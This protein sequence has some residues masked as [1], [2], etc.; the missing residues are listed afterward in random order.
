MACSSKLY[1]F[2][3]GLSL[4]TCGM[5]GTFGMMARDEFGN[6]LASFSPTVWANMVPLPDAA[7]GPGGFENRTQAIH[8]RL[9]EVQGVGSQRRSNR[10][11]A[12]VYSAGWYLLN[13]ATLVKGGLAATYYY[14][15]PR[16]FSSLS[17][18]DAGAE[19]RGAVDT[20]LGTPFEIRQDSTVDFSANAS[21]GWGQAQGLGMHV[22]GGFNVRWGGVMVSTP[23]RLWGTAAYNF[24]VRLTQSEQRVRLWA[25]NV[26]L[27]DQWSSLASLVASCH[28]PVTAESGRIAPDS[29]TAS[30]ATA[31]FTHGNRTSLSLR[32][33]YAGHTS[34]SHGITLFSSSS[35]TPASSSTPS[36]ATE[37]AVLGS[38]VLYQA[39]HAHGSP[40]K[41]RARH[42][43]ISGPK[44]EFFHVKVSGDAVSLMTAGV[45]GS[46]RILMRDEWANSIDSVDQQ[47]EIFT[48]F[49]SYPTLPTVLS[50]R[51]LNGSNTTTL[52]LSLAFDAAMPYNLVANHSIAIGTQRRRIA[53]AVS[54]VSPHMTPAGETVRH[55]RVSLATPLSSSPAPDEDYVIRVLG[56]LPTTW[57]SI[58]QVP[59]TLEAS[60]TVTRASSM[61]LY[62]QVARAGGLTAS[63]YADPQHMD[64]AP[65]LTR[66]DST[67][68][69]SAAASAGGW[70]GVGAMNT[71]GPETVVAVKWRGFVAPRFSQTYTFR[72]TIHDY[73][74]S[75]HNQRVALWIDNQQ[76]IAQW[77]SLSSL[78]PTG[79]FS[80]VPFST[81]GPSSIGSGARV[82]RPFLFEMHY[83][84]S[85]AGARRCKL[86]WE[87]TEYGRIH[88][89]QPIHN[90]RL[91]YPVDLDASPYHVLVR[92]GYAR[93]AMTSWWGQYQGLLPARASDADATYNTSFVLRDEFGNARQS[94]CLFVP[95]ASNAASSSASAWPTCEDALRLEIMSLTT[96]RVTLPPITLAYPAN[97]NAGLLAAGWRAPKVSTAQADSLAGYTAVAWRVSPFRLYASALLS[98]EVRAVT[99][100]WY[101][102][103]SLD[104]LLASLPRSFPSV[105]FTTG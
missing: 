46:F 56:Q 71:S 84:D 9:L 54:S 80:F 52:L 18:D 41:L 102:G 97:N 36:A 95:S 81:A 65:M 78:V 61:F 42:G 96:G 100:A 33:D 89:A 105:S 92:P 48:V 11:G 7:A 6:D 22:P 64:G 14:P 60:L 73:L 34:V 26:L 72:A 50:G 38:D 104:F 99:R 77:S 40:F 23:H 45:V 21:A 74:G 75:S 51:C 82:S 87:S 94:A 25:D 31:A 63:Y 17:S 30:D 101:T 83:K 15:P 2:G 85:E 3:N 13:L 19:L 88:E 68:D 39:V 12:T 47:T 5:E 93:A 27:I 16:S 32:L 91:F 76:V 98:L 86:E 29:S 4:A 79:T 35:F 28:R 62:A 1:T 59:N 49:A 70:P 43:P 20:A 103:H 24:S 67:I 55:I 90:Q 37:E 69:F 44:S 58:T 57:G 66:Q 8:P 53:S 10:Y